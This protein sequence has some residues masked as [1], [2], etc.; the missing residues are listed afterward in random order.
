MEPASAVATMPSMATTAPYIFVHFIT[1]RLLP[2]GNWI[3]SRPK[4][5]CV[6]VYFVRRWLSTSVYEPA[7]PPATRVAFVRDK[8]DDHT[9]DS[10]GKSIRFWA[11]TNT[12]AVGPFR[13][14]NLSSATPMIPVT[15]LDAGAGKAGLIQMIGGASGWP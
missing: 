13:S 8:P 12:G 3:V 14:P 5:G 2:L 11:S 7:L 15:G 9:A 10:D 6:G 1:Q 4:R